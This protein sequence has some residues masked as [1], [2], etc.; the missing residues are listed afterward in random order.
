MDFLGF[1][2]LTFSAAAFSV[3]FASCGLA[4]YRCRRRPPQP[5]PR[6]CPPVTLVKPLCGR[7]HFSAETIASSFTIDYPQYEI[8]FCVAD[9]ADPVI[10]LVEQLMAQHPESGARLLIGNDAMS[11]NPK[12]NNMAKGFRQARHELIAFVDSN[13]FTPPDYLNQ[14]VHRLQQ[15]AG[16]VSAPPVGLMPIGFWAKLECAFL[17]SYQARMQYAVDTLGMGFAQGKTLFFRRADLDH[18]GFQQ[19]AQEPA[20]D[21]AA[22]KLMQA[23]GLNVCLAGPFAQLVGPRTASQVWKR[24][25]RWARL[26]RASFPLWF[27]PEI[28]AGALPPLLAFAAG[29]STHD[30]FSPLWLL[31]FLAAWYA[32][33]LLLARFCGWPRAWGSLLLRDLTLPLIYAAG[34]AGSGFEWHGKQMTASR[35]ETPPS[36]TAAAFR[37]L[38]LASRGLRG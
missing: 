16:M 15:G 4:L 30:A 10:P 28:L 7:E 14:L 32:P 3:Q 34:C 25:V 27:A 35:E 22:T 20:E 11:S 21:A 26:R 9:G 13:V 24:Q 2:C 12:L 8:L 29:L 1:T 37:K 38:R 5:A 33:E 31:A 17:N 36:R 18:G 19:L 6:E 23:K